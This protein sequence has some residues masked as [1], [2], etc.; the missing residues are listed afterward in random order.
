M[1]KYAVT[2]V[3]KLGNI[4][5]SY[6]GRISNNEEGYLLNGEL[7]LKAPDFVK[8]ANVHNFNYHPK[9]YA[10][11]LFNLTGHIAGNEKSLS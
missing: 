7:E 6:S 3:S 2:T 8:L 10:L 9:G 1:D 5:L 4:D 11:G